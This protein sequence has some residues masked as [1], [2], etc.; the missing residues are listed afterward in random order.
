MALTDRLVSMAESVGKVTGA[1]V[2]EL[3]KA[4]APSLNPGGATS[5]PGSWQSA[6]A[7][8]RAAGGAQSFGVW[9]GPYG[10]MAPLL[11][12][13]IDF[14]PDGTPGDPR[15]TEFMPGWNLRYA[16]RLAEWTLLKR[17]A[18]TVQIVRRC[19][20]ENVNT[21]SS[22]HWTWTP[23]DQVVADIM[24]SYN[25]SDGSKNS[26]T[27]NHSRANKIAREKFAPQL[28]A[29]QRFWANPYPD[30]DRDEVDW[31]KEYMWNALV[32][33]AG[34][35]FPQYNLGGQCIGFEVIEGSTIRP[36][37]DATGRVP[38]PPLPAYQQP[39]YG[40][41][42]SDLYAGSEGSNDPQFF[43]DTGRDESGHTTKGR[44]LSYFVRAPRTF[45]PYG[46]SPVEE[47]LP[48]AYLWVKYLEWLTEG[49]RSGTIPTAFIKTDGAVIGDPK[50]QMTWMQTMTDFLRG[51]TEQRQ[52]MLPL[53]EGFDPVFAP[54]IEERYKAD[55]GE[56]VIKQCI[57]PFGVAP[58]RVGIIP[59]TGLGGKGQQ[60]GEQDQ[61]D[62][63]TLQ[64][65]ERELERVKTKLARRFLGLGPEI[66]AVCQGGDS[67][68]RALQQAQA[69]QF[70]LFSARR[71]VND[72]REEDGEPDYD[73]PLADTP[74]LIF[75]GAQEPFF[76]T[77]AN[78]KAMG[79][80]P[81]GTA[82]E[83]DDDDDVPPT[84]LGQ[85]QA[86]PVPDGQAQGD[87]E[88]G[89][90]APQPG[91]PGGQAQ[92]DVANKLYS[93]L[94]GLVAQG[95]VPRER[96]RQF[97]GYVTRRRKRGDWTDFAFGDDVQPGDAARLNLLAKR[98]VT[99]AE[100]APPVPFTGKATRPRNL[101]RI[102]K[103]YGPLVHAALS[104]VKGIDAAIT[105]AQMAAPATNDK[106]ADDVDP[107][108]LR[109]A[110]RGHLSLDPSDL[111][112]L[113]TT[114]YGD[115]WA[116]GAKAALSALP[117]GATYATAI[118]EAVRAI[119]WSDW[120]PG[121]GLAA[122]QVTQGGLTALWQRAGFT[123]NGIAATTLDR[124][125]DVIGE[126]IANGRTFGEAGDAVSAFLGDA[127]RA[128]VIA[129]TETNRA[130]CA[131]SLEQYQANGAQG[132]D[133]DVGSEDPCPTCE[134]AQDANPHD[135]GDDAPPYHP[136]CKCAVV[137]DFGSTGASG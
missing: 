64:P 54:T 126:A 113:L 94:A 1:G 39:L 27:C 93:T 63:S 105:A 4:M 48:W 115:G 117:D 90:N 26:P 69:A 77:E 41:P 20:D 85:L 100:V 107:A 43:A 15:L 10:P 131:S 14:K 29:M 59:R 92:A 53:P 66:R 67:D 122:T 82:I 17:T 114:L 137:A 70:S 125:G 13:P 40:F 61:A 9:G 130:F 3:R 104:K 12:V 72:Q 11:P 44:Q 101:S 89:G 36:L 112:K 81:D 56:Y 135:F 86:N 133:S 24:A 134:A 79:L 52:S 84:P 46:F 116:V 68:D 78:A 108:L 2:R 19:I 32:Y 76:L 128:D 21:L 5:Y 42:R 23:T 124:I 55:F 111:A 136:N 127:T 34:C 99:G 30:R 121:N 57:A 129:M 106:A 88:E 102:V 118:G 60:E 120:T 31:D 58:T 103:H 37:R 75:P 119:S 87:D 16:E 123:S 65:W 132:W 8:A 28:S 47:V 62:I 73:N 109:Q 38:R 33:D 6:M 91:G 74:F 18:E 49:F 96:S 83:E 25:R 110:A 95:A 45:T 80:N 71:T 7:Q 98:Y 51:N 97:K 50:A 22:R 35:V